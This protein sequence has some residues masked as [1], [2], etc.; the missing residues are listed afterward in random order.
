MN[1]DA[2]IPLGA[3][4]ALDRVSDGVLALDADFCCTYCNGP[5]AELLEVGREGILGQPIWEAV[6]DLL[7]TKAETNL[8]E[9]MN[10]RAERCFER[11][12]DTLERWFEVTIYPSGDGVSI[13]LT[14]VTERK[15]TER[16]KDKV[17]SQLSALVENTEEAIYIKDA[18]GRYQLMNAA[19]AALFDEHP[20][21]VVG[22]R[23][24]A[25]FD[26][27]SAAAIRAVDE[28]ILETGEAVTE[29]RVLSIDGEKHV[30]L[31]NKYPY[32]DA[33]GEVVGVMGIS[34]EITERHSF[35]NRLRTL[36]ETVRQLNSE[37][38][39]AGI[40]QLALDAAVDIL[41]F[42][43]A[44][45]WLYDDA[46][47]ALVPAAES[48][49]AREAV[50]PAPTFESGD[51][52]A[53]DVF[54]SGEYVASENVAAKDDVYNPDTPLGAEVIVP[55]GEQGI[56]SMSSTSTGVFSDADVELFRI[57]AAATREALVRADREAEFR[58]LTEEY[59]A[60][61]ENTADAIFL[62]DVHHDDEEPTFRYERLSP[63]HEELSGLRTEAVR[64][65]TPEEAL[66]PEEGAAVAEN[67]RRCVAAGESIQ[68]EEEIEMPEGTLT[69]QT[70]LAPVVVDGEV[71][72][73][74]GIARD[75]TER[76]EQ[77]RALRR[78]NERLD[79]FASVISHDLRNPLNVAQGRLTLLADEHESEHL[80]PIETALARMDD[81]I[82]DTL[83]LARDGREVAE[84]T[85][86]RI[87][88]VVGHS[89][90][91]V[92][93][94]NAALEIGEP[95]ELE[96]DR[97]RLRHVFENLFRNALQHGGP[98]VTVK[99]ERLADGFAVTDDGPGIPAERAAK[100]FE[101]GETTDTDGTGFGLAIVKGIA[102][103]HGWTVAVT[104]GAAGGA[105]FEFRGVDVTA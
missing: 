66:G 45:I 51:G 33:D 24:D 5:A 77:E 41:E 43:V 99:V 36:Q 71:S 47:E 93:T 46:A 62:V 13:Y 42:P 2:T 34:R 85:T 74:V 63:S 10:E 30:F 44:A 83:T 100:V 104:E 32:R 35:E 8:R 65:Q 79:E 28:E 97:D 91:V 22:M 20:E 48:A 39:K 31:D 6:P 69:W 54:E 3:A 1:E 29:E 23:D 86:L 94:A 92:D 78:K 40:A 55:L 87:T 67:Y 102:E 11:Y 76:V 25:L 95:F 12:N 88:D 64:G 81:I 9:S 59:E 7:G 38:S 21:A 61:L 72:R 17:T 60:L 50:G 4:D 84:T 57:L 70:S 68:Y 105:R 80:E 101:A 82:T 37:Q 15:R 103:A 98:S 58:E 14:D 26:E 19:G 53:W 96:A 75:L 73:I 56:M 27:E 89:W 49:A 16:D 52:L 90:G 18:D